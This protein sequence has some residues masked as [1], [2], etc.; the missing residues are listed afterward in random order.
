[1]PHLGR[2]RSSFALSV[3]VAAVVASVAATMSVAQAKA[4]TGV[5]VT[6][7]GRLVT[8]SNEAATATESTSVSPAAVGDVLTLAIETKFPKGSPFTAASVTGGGVATWRKAAAYLTKDGTHGEELWWGVVATPGASTVTAAYGS[9]P[10][11]AAT[12]LDVQE[13]QS[14]AGAATTWSLDTTGT[15]DT[16]VAGTAMYPSLTASASGEAYSGYVA[17][18]GYASPGS[19]AGVTYATDARGNQV[20]YAPAVS[21]TLQPAAAGATQTYA[22]IGMLLRAQVSSTPSPT[23]SPTPK[24]TASPT[25]SP[26]TV[27]AV[28]SL[29]TVTDQPS[30]AT[31]SVTVPSLAVG[32][33]V[34]V[35]VET[36]FPGTPSFSST[37][38][39]G[40]GVS[41]WKQA[42]SFLTLDGFH[43]QD[44]WWGVVT[45]PG[46]AGLTVSYGAGATAGTADSATSVDVQVLRSSAG[47]STSWAPDGTGRVDDG[48]ST[49]TPRYPALAPTGSNEA[50]VGYMAVPSYLD[51][52]GTPGV[53]S[54]TDARGNQVVYATSVSST[55]APSTT[56]PSQTFAS[57]G[58]LFRVR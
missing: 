46:A 48:H 1:M 54:Q 36:K 11:G 22:S 44:V 55:F 17:V 34:V 45:A 6:L 9:V 43:G 24:P 4:A 49:S 52:S 10:S 41:T 35:I 40:A 7:V 53:T 23:A 2:R 50:Y 38:V 15:L 19:T 3:A 26:A 18:P 13:M 58:V 39:S 14:S 51:P 56:S 16:G 31:E 8:Q 21:G 12:S 25:A 37:G 29:V 47:A 28:G 27:A 20:A 5:T 32:D 33:L 30:L 42:L 57:S